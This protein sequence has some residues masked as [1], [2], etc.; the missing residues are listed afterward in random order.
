MKKTI[1]ITAILLA[2]L[3]VKAQNITDIIEQ[4]VSTAEPKLDFKPYDKWHFSFATGI[5]LTCFKTAPTMEGNYRNIKALTN[6][7]SASA[8]YK[9]SPRLSLYSSLTYYK[10]GFSNASKNDANY[11]N[12]DA[13]TAS[14]GA[15]YQ[16]T[17]SLSVG[18][19]VRQSKNV[20]PYGFY[21]GN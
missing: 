13:Y 8:N 2:A 18:L 4:H 3:N 17:P 7:Y 9:A 12:R 6:Y 5:S 20:N 21:Y 10:N 11:F 16:I 14:F 1:F 15:N 19:E